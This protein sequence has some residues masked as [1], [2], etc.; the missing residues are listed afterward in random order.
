MGRTKLSEIE[1][2][3]VLI[4]IKLGVPV[5][6]IAVELNLSKQIVYMLLKAA[7]GLPDGTV[8]LRKIGSG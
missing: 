5:M 3:Q 8:P 1:K 4:K 7:K 2:A 6:K